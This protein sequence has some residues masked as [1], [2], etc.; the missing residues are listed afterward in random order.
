MDCTF[1]LDCVQ[2]CPHDN[3][4]IM[5]RLPAAELTIDTQRSG[6]GFF[7]R[8]K[9]LAALSVVFTFGAV[10]NAFGMVSPVYAAQSWLAGVLRIN[11]EAP[12]LGLIF[13]AGL[14]IEPAL[15]LVLAAWLTKKW[16]GSR[17]AILPLIIRHSYALVP[18][19]F[20][21]WLSHYGF[22]FLTGLYTIIPV[23]QSAVASAG[24]PILGD[25]MWRL[26][27][28]SENAVYPIEMGFLGL[29]LLGSL[30]VSYRM[31]EEDT[32]SHTGRV[33]SVWAG[34]CFLLWISAMWLL[35]Q[36][37][38]MRGTFMGG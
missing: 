30:L 24:W 22:H 26:G 23:F 6:I 15:L 11:Q 29:G 8:R 1:C 36:P 16:G 33:F 2:A 37:M 34:L 3:V 7:S 25:P 28:L 32:E 10:L 14:I 5:S 20:G 12:I 27:G 35:S 19:G 4:G 9:D 21:I 38:E 13:I 18:L 31:A 17:N